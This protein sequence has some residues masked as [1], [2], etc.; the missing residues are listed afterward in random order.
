MQPMTL[1]DG[2]CEIMSCLTQAGYEAYVVGG[3]V[4]D[5]LR[6]IT[7][8]DYDMTTN[9]TPEEMKQV[10]NAYR[11]IETGIRHG[12]LTVLVGREAYELTTYRVD[13]DY[14]DH[15]HP[16][17][18]TFTRSLTED[19]AR[20]DFTMNAIAYHPERGYADPF[21]GIADITQGVIRAVGEPRLRF[22]EDA[23]RILRVLRFAATLNYTIDEKTAKAAYETR[24]LLLHVSRERCRDE[25]CKLLLGAHAARILRD[26]HP[27]LQVCLPALT[28]PDDRTLSALRVLS[29]DPIL[30]LVCLM[31]PSFGDDPVRMEALMRD[32]RFDSLSRRRAIDL[33]EFIRTPLT[34]EVRDIC[35]LLTKIEPDTILDLCTLTEA[36]AEEPA[37]R[38]E[39]AAMRATTL[40]IIT[41]SI[42][43]RITHLAVSGKDVLSVTP[44]RGAAVGAALSS[45]LTAV[46]DGEVE[47]SRPA[48]LRYLK[49]H[50]TSI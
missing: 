46:I 15:R 41:E 34:T 12:T 26:F 17:D 11:L 38:E 50:H 20:R 18:V 1:P 48:L 3:C 24:E 32:L 45:L 33:A 44:L 43:Y 14:R 27:I 47:N 31:R 6:G 10:L 25:L 28:P 30:R 5:A 39:A 8:H 36:L 22:E 13:G 19:L 40:R 42:P 49:A 35:R 9:A 21:D 2:V 37:V 16:T 29:E 7:P 23:L 4:R